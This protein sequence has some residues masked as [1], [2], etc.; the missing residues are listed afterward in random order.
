MRTSKKWTQAGDEP[1]IGD[2]LDDPIA[3]ALMKADGVVAA[4][5]LTVVDRAQSRRATASAEKPKR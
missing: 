5:V 1:P 4:E 2:L 3:H